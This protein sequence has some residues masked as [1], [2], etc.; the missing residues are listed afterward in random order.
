MEEFNQVSAMKVDAKLGDMQTAKLKEWRE[1]RDNELVDE[2]LD[3]LSN[4]AK[5]GKFV[6][7]VIDAVRNKS[8]LGEIMNCLKQEYGTWM[9]PS[10]F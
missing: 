4:A 6:P 9:A 1:L 7:I 10:G 2:T 3:R 5:Q 8:T